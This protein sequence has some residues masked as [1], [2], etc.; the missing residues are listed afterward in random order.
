MPSTAKP[1][2]RPTARHPLTD[3]GADTTCVQGSGSSSLPGPAEHAGQSCFLRGGCRGGGQE[4]GTGAAA[5]Q[6]VLPPGS[7]RELTA[8]RDG[9]G[10]TRPGT[11]QLL[12][13]IPSSNTAECLC[14]S[15]TRQERHVCIARMMYRFACRASTALFPPSHQSCA[16]TELF[17]S[18]A[19]A[20]LQ[21]RPICDRR[22]TPPV[23][24]FL[25]C[26]NGFRAKR[27]EP[28]EGSV[29]RWHPAPPPPSISEHINT[30]ET[31]GTATAHEGGCASRSR[32]GKK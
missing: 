19:R 18:R 21:H 6:D 16:S 13:R 10:G 15:L 14:F 1:P 2:R 5:P 17:T 25:W 29:G 22:R 4:I 11:E 7:P 20:R 23:H 9:V 12:W 32:I 31:Q 27:W 26:Q 28:T 8:P 3:P 30:R 24:M